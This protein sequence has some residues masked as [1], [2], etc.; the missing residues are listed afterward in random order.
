ML[1]PKWL[2]LSIFLHGDL[3]FSSSAGLESDRQAKKG[4]APYLFYRY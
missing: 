3:R 2:I 1:P 4:F